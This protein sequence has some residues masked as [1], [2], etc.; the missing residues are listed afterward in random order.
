MGEGYSGGMH[1]QGR[2]VQQAWSI[3]YE[4][5]TTAVETMWT[6]AHPGQPMA[7]LCSAS[8]YPYPRL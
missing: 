4:E 2:A 1:T 7:G 5:V 6:V 8:L 3:G